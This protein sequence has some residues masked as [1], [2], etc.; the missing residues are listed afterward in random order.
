MKKRIHVWIYGVVKGVFFRAQTKEEA[1]KLGLNGCVRNTAEGV[2]AVFEGDAEALKKILEFCK[3]GPPYSKVDKVV[4]KEENYTGE[5][6]DFK[7]L[8]F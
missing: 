1:D 3:K 2:E 4:S 5:F 8:Y 6:K 7:I